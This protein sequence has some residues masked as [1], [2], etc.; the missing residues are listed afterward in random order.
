MGITGINN[1]RSICD[2]INQP[3]ILI[4]S[5]A[6]ITFKFLFQRFWL[7]LAIKRSADNVIN[8]VTFPEGCAAVCFYPVP[9]FVKVF[10]NKFNSL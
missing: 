6:P 8:K 9:I 5:P 1:Q 10:W 4:N 3:V 7:P 2:F